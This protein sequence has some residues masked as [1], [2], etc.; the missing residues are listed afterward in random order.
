MEKQAFYKQEL[1]KL[2]QIFQDV[3]P[4][5]ASLVQGLIEDA[6]FLAAENYELRKL[7]AEKGMV[8]VHPLHPELQKPTEAGKQYLKNLNSY[9]VVIKTLNSVLSK[10]ILDEDEDLSEFE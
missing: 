4:T 7:M 8:K 2:T 3:E 10:N 6:A 9:A 1:A 5:K